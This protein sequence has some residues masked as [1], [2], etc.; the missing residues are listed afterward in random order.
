MVSQVEAGGAPT[1]EVAGVAVD[2]GLLL[3]QAVAMAGQYDQLPYDETAAGPTAAGGGGSV[4]SD[5]LGD[6][7]DLLAA[8]GVIPPVATQFGVPD[9]GD[10][11]GPFGSESEPGKDGQGAERERV[12]PYSA[13]S[14]V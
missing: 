12:G 13:R 9:P 2:T 8:Q 14:G 1:F 5:N 3:S 10:E 7:L 6:V 11:I 4:Y